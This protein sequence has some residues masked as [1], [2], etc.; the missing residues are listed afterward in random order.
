MQARIASANSPGTRSGAE[1]S[2]SAR[3]TSRA[4]G[5]AVRIRWRTGKARGSLAEAMH[6]T[7]PA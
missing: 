6:N 5:N 4:C 3:T 2:P 7:G 1:M